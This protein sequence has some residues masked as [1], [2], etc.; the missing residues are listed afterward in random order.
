MWSLGS[1]TGDWFE[2]RANSTVKCPEDIEQDSWSESNLFGWDSFGS[3]N[4]EI[5]CADNIHQTMN[6]TT[7]TISGILLISGGKILKAQVEWNNF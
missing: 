5:K 3:L 4:V 1:V 7:A 2:V 6:S